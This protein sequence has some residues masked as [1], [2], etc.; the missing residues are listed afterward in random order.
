MIDRAPWIARFDADT[1][2]KEGDHVEV[3]VDT[4]SLHFFDP[5][6]AASIWG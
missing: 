1:A 5:E 4:R 6:T 3:L 2:A